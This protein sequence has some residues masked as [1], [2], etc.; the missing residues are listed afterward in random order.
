MR[1]PSMGFV[2]GPTNGNIVSQH[3]C[4]MSIFQTFKKNKKTRNK[5]KLAKKSRKNNR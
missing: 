4:D 5:N 2:D 3:G 1:K